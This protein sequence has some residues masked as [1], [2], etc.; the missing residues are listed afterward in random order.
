MTVNIES[1][2]AIGGGGTAA[3]QGNW[4][5]LSIEVPEFFKDLQTSLNSIMELLT[6]ALDIALSALNLAKTF[7]TS[8]LDPIQALIEAVVSE[9]R[10]VLSDFRNVG[11]YVTGDWP[12]LKAPFTDLIG[13][14]QEFERRMI[15]RMTDRTDPTRP[16]VASTTSVFGAFFFTAGEA[17]ELPQIQSTLDQ[18]GQFLNIKQAPEAGLPVP[19]I[20]RVEYGNQATS[21][22]SYQSLTNVVRFDPTP[23][24]IARITWTL[25]APSSGDPLESVYQPPPAGFMVTVSTVRDGIPLMY[26]RPRVNT[27]KESRGNKNN[28]E[29]RQQPREYGPVRDLNGKP[30][31]LHGGYD[32]LVFNTDFFGYANSYDDKGRIKDGRTRVYGVHTVADQKIIPLGD[33]FSSN[34]EEGPPKGKDYVFQRTFWVDPVSTGFQWVTGEYSITLNLEDLPYP[35]SVT[36]QGQDLFGFGQGSP[37][38]TYYV[39]VATVGSRDFLGSQPSRVWKYDLDSTAVQPLVGASGKPFVVPMVGGANPRDMSAMSE[40]AQVVFPDVNTK[41]YLEAVK[42]A[43]A[44]LVLTRAD[45]PVLENLNEITEREKALAKENKKLVNGV[46]LLGTGLERFKPLLDLIY[47]DAGSITGVFDRPWS[48]PLDFRQSLFRRINT[49]ARFLYEQTGPMPAAEK[50]IAEST[51]TLRN[52]T[53]DSIFDSLGTKRDSAIAETLRAFTKSTNKPLTILNSLDTGVDDD[54]GRDISELLTLSD[55]ELNPGGANREWGVASSPYSMGHGRDVVDKLFKVIDP[56]TSESL[57]VT[58]RQPHFIEFPGGAGSFDPK[59]ADKAAR[60]VL[61]EISADD[62][63]AFLEGVHPGLRLVYE[64]HRQDDGSI[65][66]DQEEAVYYEEMEEVKRLVGS[67]DQSPVFYFGFSTMPEVDNDS[68]DVLSVSKPVEVAYC[69][70]LLAGYLGGEILTEAAYT[71]GVAASAGMR[72]PSDGAWLSLRMGDIL[73]SLEDFLDSLLNWVESISQATKSAADALVT[74]IA[75]VED[76]IADLQQFLQRINSLIQMSFSFGM[77]IPQMNGL[78]LYSNGTDGLL[79]DF[80]AAQ[81]KPSSSPQSYG[82][83]V[84]LVAPSAPALLGDLIKLAEGSPQAGDTMVEE[85]PADLFS[86]EGISEE[87]LNPPSDPEPDVL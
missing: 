13:G 74:Y 65:L 9:L 4:G 84:A 51:G 56:V 5:T 33:L 43:L 15:A 22:L 16:N 20:Q 66:L 79:A 40:P 80:V 54:L 82:A 7:L 63:D 78:L 48:D 2:T 8:Y 58:Y 35:G 32:H 50:A 70:T 27:N 69:R 39:R 72:S 49:V 67:A 62:A 86:I 77:R 55:E 10:E 46:A 41:P 64:R 17:E 18:M 85:P 19:R 76:R 36:G 11:V 31:V 87:D 37:A 6:S 57:V 1:G 45:L 61:R 23:S 71:L 60:G 75:F 3:G 73:P 34:D 21:V 52:V 68:Y 26:D 28:D 42:A 29:D 47:N 24:Q 25:E 44:V 83:G 14:Y 38:D 81:N 53:W 30:I 12:L 59:A